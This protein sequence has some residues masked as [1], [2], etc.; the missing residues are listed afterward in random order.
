MA[1]LGHDSNHHLYILSEKRILRPPYE[2]N[3]LNFWPK[4]Q[5]LVAL[6]ITHI[7]F[8]SFRFLSI[9]LHRF[10][11]YIT[12]NFLLTDPEGKVGTNFKVSRRTTRM[13][14]LK[15]EFALFNHELVLMPKQL[16]LFS[17]QLEPFVHQFVRVRFTLS[18]FFL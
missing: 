3:H 8:K 9:I 13:G 18:N 10:H 15:L 5:I 17:H 12:P 11:L 1:H 16:V 6:E 14:Y 4:G 2:S 7:K